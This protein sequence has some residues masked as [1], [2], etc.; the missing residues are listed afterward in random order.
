MATSFNPITGAS[1][2]ES[3]MIQK[4]VSFTR[5][6]NTTAYAIGDAVAPVTSTITG[7]TNANPSVI[8]TSAAHGLVTGDR[9]TIAGS[10][11][12]TAINGTWQVVVLTAT[13]FSIKTEAG[14]AVAGNGAWTSGGTVQKL[15][16]FTEVVPAAGGSGSIVAIRLQV[17]NG[18]VTLGTFRVRLYTEPITQ[19][20]DNAAFTLLD[21]NRDKR[22]GYVDLDILATDGAGSDAAETVKL[23]DQPIPFTCAPTRT[24]LFAQIIALGAFVP[25]SGDTFKLEITI[26]RDQIPSLATTRRI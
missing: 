9:A 19:I 2:A 5:P 10:V 23:L 13:T 16:R 1:L 7:A 21:A 14:V 15:L 24:D 17:R 6:A 26:K 25:G 22:A 11:G 20:A 3:P 12:N 4:N 8:T 18:T